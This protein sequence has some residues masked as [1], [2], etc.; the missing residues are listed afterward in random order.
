MKVYFW[1]V[2]PYGKHFDQFTRDR[3]LPY[4]LPKQHFDPEIAARSYEEHLT[5]WEELDRLGF[6]GV[7]LNEHHT[8]PHGLIASPNLIAAAA[9]QRTKNLKFITLGNLLPIHNPLQIAEDIAIADCLSRGRM[10]PGFARGN[11]REYWAYNIPASESRGRFEEALEIIVKA[12]TQ[13]VFTH[14]GKYWTF[15]DI[16][17]W[18]RPFQQPHPPLWV[19]FSGSQQTIEWAAKLNLNA[20]VAGAPPV[21]EDMVSYFAKCMRDHGRVLSPNQVLLFTESYV[22]DSKQEALREYG[23]YYLYFV[24][25]LWH[26][27]TLKPIGTGP[28]EKEGA[29][30][31]DY[32]RPENRA[33]AGLDRERIRQTNLP[34]VEKKVYG[35][36]LAW[37]SPKEVAEHL[38]EQ[39]ERAG[40]NAVLLNTCNGALPHELIMEQIRRFGRDVLPKLHA[41]EVKRVPVA[42]SAAAD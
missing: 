40:A 24:Q 14:E 4:P 35:D 12:W 22:A 16:A 30:N 2:L 17:I 6:D 3:Y 21:V 29:V 19:P 39:A 28:T 1:D 10:L 26:H 7:G 5:A 15:K 42:A 13:E 33:L 20:V 36:Q 23:P 25:T 11:A 32:L 27:G 31:V 38:I 34:D 37:G 18:P 8:T 9:I 41:H